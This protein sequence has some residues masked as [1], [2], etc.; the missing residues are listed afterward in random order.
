[1]AV[2]GLAVLVEL[3][4]GGVALEDVLRAEVRGDMEQVRDVRNK[5]VQTGVNN[6]LK[7]GGSF[8]Y[9]SIVI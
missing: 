1:M 8:L 3:G 9:K 7:G 4:L 5:V 2:V 6:L